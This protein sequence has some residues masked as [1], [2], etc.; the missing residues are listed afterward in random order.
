MALARKKAVPPTASKADLLKRVAQQT[1]PPAQPPVEKELPKPAPTVRKSVRKPVIPKQVPPVQQKEV[2][3]HGKK[4]EEVKVSPGEGTEASKPDITSERQSLPA[5]LRPAH[6]GE[7]RKVSTEEMRAMTME[8]RYELFRSLNRDESAE[9][10][11]PIRKELPKQVQLRKAEAVIRKII[12]GK[13]P[14]TPKGADSVYYCPYCVDWQPFHNFSWLG[15]VK[16]CGCTISVRDFYTSTDNGVF[17][18]V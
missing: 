11:I 17:G 4:E 7:N 12:D 18:K 9:V 8:Q 6:P 5:K 13:V 14:K 16:C 10:F 3:P 2:E 15:S 1:V